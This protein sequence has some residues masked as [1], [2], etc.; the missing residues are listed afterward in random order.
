MFTIRA[1]SR[2]P[3]LSIVPTAKER[4]AKSVE[5]IDEE[6][7]AGESEDDKEESDDEDESEEEEEEEEEEERDQVTILDSDV[8]EDDIGQTVASGTQRT[9]KSVT[10]IKTVKSS[11]TVT[12][13]PAYIP[14]TDTVEMKKKQ[15]KRKTTHNGED[16]QVVE[17]TEDKD[18][19]EHQDENMHEENSATKSTEETDGCR[20]VM[21]RLR[22]LGS[23]PR[24]SKRFHVIK[25]HLQ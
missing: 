18:K 23:D 2:N 12:T 20:W 22:G 13:L 10:T 21:Q 24:G 14:E 9:A 5:E 3:D 15:K 1:M 6:D 17:T 8:D 7:D 11:N 19:G 25:V 4:E 16:M